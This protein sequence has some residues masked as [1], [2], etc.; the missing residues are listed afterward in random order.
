MPPDARG[1]PLPPEIASLPRDEFR[2]IYDRATQVV[3]GFTKSRPR[4]EELVQ[5][6]SMLLLTTRRWDPSKGPL[7]QHFLGIVRSVLSHSYS[8]EKTER[9]ARAAQTREDFQRE[10]V[11]TEAA[12]PEDAT[13]DGTD[14][15]D[16]Q[17]AAERELD[18]L[19]ASV[20]GSPDAQRVLRARRAG[21]RKK[22]AAEIALELGLPVE[23]VYRAN[24]LLLNHLRR[25]R[26]QPA[27]TAPGVAP[28]PEPGRTVEDTEVDS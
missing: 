1:Q 25:I 18:E 19:D 22:K 3:F 9:G 20:A 21:D 17:A 5:S 23:R 15:A 27:G 13:I 28:L 14:G 26:A 12:S 8:R 16:R 24:K 4:T 2:A 6:A 10:V 11:G 7:L